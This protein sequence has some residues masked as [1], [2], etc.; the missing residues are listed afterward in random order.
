MERD[1]KTR[2]FPAADLAEDLELWLEGRA[3]IARRA[4]ASLRIWRWSKCNPVFAGTLAAAVGLVLLNVV[5]AF[6][7]S[8]LLSLIGQARL[9]RHTIA[10]VQ[11]ENLRELTPA[12]DSI[13]EAKSLVP[14]AI[15]KPNPS[16]RSTEGPKADALPGGTTTD[17]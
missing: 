13:T 6:T 10:S 11:F 1:P 8:H 9:A 17:D 5:A 15:G 16:Q 14:A 2:Y 12:L 4:S 3:I 7:I